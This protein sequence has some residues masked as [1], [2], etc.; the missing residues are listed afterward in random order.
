M[1]TISCQMRVKLN[2]GR[3]SMADSSLT[4]NITD[5]C[6]V[7][8]KLQSCIPHVKVLIVKN[9][10]V[11]FLVG[12]DLHKNH[13][14]V[15]IEFIG[16]KPPLRICSLA[17]TRVVPVALFSNWTPNCRPIITNVRHQTEEDKVIASEIR[18]LLLEDVIEEIYSPWKAKAFIV[19]GEYHKIK[20]VVDYSQS[21]NTFTML[22]A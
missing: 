20:Q 15:E 2:F 13:S 3:I 16:D 7:T 8:I 11:D 9:L 4:S 21:I 10:C 18:K 19:K 17:I 14:F 1:D 22:D 6:S 5:C 12:H